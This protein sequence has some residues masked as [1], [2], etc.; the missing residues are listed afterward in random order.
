MALKT[1]LC[2]NETI[3]DGTPGKCGHYLVILPT[4][5][6]ETLKSIQGKPDSHILTRCPSCRGSTKFSKIYYKNDKLTFESLT[7][8]EV[9]PE[10]VKYDDYIICA[11][12]G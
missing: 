12:G 10:P 1:L 6:L 4:E 9:F 11:Q 7:Q 2:R 3:I 5:L 8:E